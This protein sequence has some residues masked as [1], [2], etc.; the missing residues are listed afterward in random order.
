MNEQQRIK[1]LTWK[2]FFKQKVEEIK[3]NIVN[4]ASFT[5]TF[6]FLFIVIGLIM[7]EAGL[8]GGNLLLWIGISI[9]IFWILILIISLLKKS[10]NWLKS[11]WK[12]A[13]EKAIAEVKYG[14][15]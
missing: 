9:L 15:K 7:I 1:S 13:K 10:K 8:F 11:N 2:Y 3:E 14:H 4:I 12:K 6:S 5:F